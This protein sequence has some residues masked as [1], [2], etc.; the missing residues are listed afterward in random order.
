MSPGGIWGVVLG[1]SRPDGGAT[2]VGVGKVSLFSDFIGGRPTYYV[3]EKYIKRVNCISY[4]LI[5]GVC[6]RREHIFPYVIL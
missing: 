1:Y 3:E 6:V 2:R 5:S 4:V